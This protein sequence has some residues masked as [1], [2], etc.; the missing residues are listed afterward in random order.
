MHDS[1]SVVVLQWVSLNS[2][3]MNESIHPPVHLLPALCHKLVSIPEF[4]QP[5]QLLSITTTIYLKNKKLCSFITVWASLLMNFQVLHL[6]TVYSLSSC[7]GIKCPIVILCCFHPAPQYCGVYYYYCYCTKTPSV[8]EDTFSSAAFFVCCSLIV[9]DTKLTQWTGEYLQTAQKDERW[10]WQWILRHTHNPQWIHP[11]CHGPLV[12]VADD[13]LF[14]G[15]FMWRKERKCWARV[16][17]LIDFFTW[18]VKESSVI[19]Y[20]YCFCNCCCCYMRRVSEWN[21]YSLLLV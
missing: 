19:N 5:W 3:R 7:D 1:V 15:K 4:V 8:V 17:W 20:M 2:Q 14:A 6:P 21:C 9:I 16:H 18:L 13:C 11:P 12:V 10:R